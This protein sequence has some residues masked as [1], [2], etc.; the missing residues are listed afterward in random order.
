MAVTAVEQVV[1]TTVPRNWEILLDYRVSSNVVLS[2]VM[3]AYRRIK[4]AMCVRSTAFVSVKS[5]AWE[6]SLVMSQKKLLASGQLKLSRL[7]RCSIRV[8][9]CHGQWAIQT[10][11]ISTV[12][13]TQISMSFTTRLLRVDIS[14]GVASREINARN[15]LV[16]KIQSGMISIV[17]HATTPC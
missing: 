5:F 6:M 12:A 3:T 13:K 9:Q 1:S 14:Q 10:L 8:V 7:K 17:W 11:S 15:C 16:A 2:M 4:V